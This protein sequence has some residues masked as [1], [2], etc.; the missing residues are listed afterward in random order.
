[1]S[2]PPLTAGD[3]G[4]LAVYAG[5]LWVPGAL[6]ALAARARGWTVAA[7]APL[8]TYGLVGLLGPLAS[9]LGWFWSPWVLLAGAAVAALVAAGLGVLSGPRPPALPTWTRVAHLSTSVC[10]AV[11]SLVGLAAVVGGMGGLRTIPQDWDA[12]L[13]ANGIRWIVEHGDAGLTAMTRVNWYE[14]PTA[15]FYPNAYHLVGAVVQ[16]LT[17]RDIPSVLNAGTVLTLAVLAVGAAA[18]VRR[19]A[20]RAVLA[21]AAALLAVAPTPFYDMLWRGPLLPFAFGAALLPALLVTVVDLLDARGPRQ[22][23]AAAVGLVLGLGGAMSLHPAVLLTGLLAAVPLVLGRWWRRPADLP[24]DALVLATAGLATA[25]VY[26][27]SILG[28]L[29]SAA[30]PSVDWPADLS[31]AEAFGDVALFAH[32]AAFPQWW[33]A[34]LVIVGLAASARL[35]QMWWLPVAG[36]TSWVLFVVAASY[37]TPWAEAI[38][39]P[40]WNDRYRF[41]GLA[42]V[43]LA[44]VAAHG[45]AVL[46]EGTREA[47]LRTIDAIARRAGG[48][49]GS[50]PRTLGVRWLVAVLAVGA[51]VLVTHGLYLGRNQVAMRHNTGEGPAVSSGE[52]AGFAELARLVPPSDRVMNDRADGSVWMYALAGVHPVAAHYDPTAAGPDVTLLENSFNR[53]DEDPAV[54]AAA[55]R[56]GVRWAVV[57]EGF[58]RPES[59]RAPGLTDLDGVRSLRLVWADPVFRIYQLVPASGSGGGSG[60]LPGTGAGDGS[61]R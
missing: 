45:F 7:V 53:Y 58:L 49:T 41:A 55:A 20:G 27:A 18:L 47:V 5:V 50:R 40:W 25:V 2:A 52:V 38:T 9:A 17:G 48:R 11:A 59:T 6:I 51:L 46:Q 28:S 36:V 42:A 35:R 29:R 10:V 37:D 56:L 34:L 1:M 22:V 26:A 60:V 54:R 12:A 3:A 32:G 8:L 24:R 14:T 19:C 4:F 15:P 31:V 23:P 13:H 30:G 33:L 43:F 57:G 44:I 16:E 39:R 21:G 61:V